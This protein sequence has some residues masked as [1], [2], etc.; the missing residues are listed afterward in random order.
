M[1]DKSGKDSQ[2]DR[3]EKFLAH[4]TK[5]IDDLSGQVNRFIADMVTIR[6]EFMKC[7]LGP[8]FRQIWDRLKDECRKM[9]GSI[10]ELT[11][12]L[13][14]VVLARTEKTRQA[15]TKEIQ[16]RFNP[17]LLEVHLANAC[18]KLPHAIPGNKHLAVWSKGELDEE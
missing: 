15:V 17:T 7:T 1:F 4:R 16:K 14:Q 8:Q 5:G 18:A 11:S 3:L 10:D 12:H 2:E 9:Q 6:D 13:S